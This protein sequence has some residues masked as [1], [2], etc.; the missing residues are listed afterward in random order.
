ME[1]EAKSRMEGKKHSHKLF[2]RGSA[3]GVPKFQQVIDVGIAVHFSMWER[4]T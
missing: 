4:E 3:S 1:V 2:L